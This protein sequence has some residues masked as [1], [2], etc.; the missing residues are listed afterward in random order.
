M[1]LQEIGCGGD[2]V[3]TKMKIEDQ[4]NGEVHLKGQCCSLED[5]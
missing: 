4:D 5:I 1:H 2:Q 3:L